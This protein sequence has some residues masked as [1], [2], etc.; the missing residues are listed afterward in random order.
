MTQEPPIYWNKFRSF[1]KCVRVSSFC[2]RLKYKRQFKFLPLEALDRAEERLL[3]MI[4]K[5]SFPELFSEK[6]SFSKSKKGG[7]LSNLYPF[8][9]KKALSELGVASNMPIQ[10]LNN[11]TLYCCIYETR[12]GDNHAARSTLGTQP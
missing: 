8:L 12:H 10:D 2:L 6:E 11:V 9:M 3:K 1:S 4:Q 5:E 7:N